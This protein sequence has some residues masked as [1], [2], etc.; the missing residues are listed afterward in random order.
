MLHHELLQ[1]LRGARLLGRAID[2]R[3]GVGER[4]SR[5]VG[6]GLEFADYREYQPGD[7]FRYLDRHIFARHGRTVLRQFHIDQRITVSVL[8]DLSASMGAGE[9]RKDQLAKQFAAALATVAL[10]GGDQVDVGFFHGAGVVWH[11]RLSKTAALP[12]LFRWLEQATPAGDVSLEAVARATSE[13]LA[14]GGMLLVISDWL[15]DGVEAALT[16]WS[17]RGQE[18]VALQV[19]APDELDPM[20]LG[21]GRLQLID[22]ERG[23]LLEVDLDGDAIRRYR[24]AFEAHQR[25][26][27]RYI[28]AVN[29]RWVSASS[30]E[31]VDDVILRRFR[32][33][34][35]L[36]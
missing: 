3:Q 22:A 6:A 27:Q 7:D 20:R 15:L 13:R 5:G 34:G 4:R 36:R 17:Q 14:A 9:P 10:Y 16:R 35:V 30:D 28:S 21:A 33:Q 2:P 31:R 32:L 1:R 11:P 23:E 25:D 24:G 12:N 8:L 18:V 19:L 29:G 26:L